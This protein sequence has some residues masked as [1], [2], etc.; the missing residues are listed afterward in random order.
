MVE[1]GK[2]AAK[3]EDANETG[4]RG[5]PSAWKW[6]VGAVAVAVV[7]WQVTQGVFVK[8]V[9]VPGGGEISFYPP[10]DAD[11]PNPNKATIRGA[12]NTVDQSG[13]AGN[14][15]TINGYRNVI[16]Q[17]GSNNRAT[18]GGPND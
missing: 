1:D 18:T 6:I 16:V 9:S 14:R 8:S 2:T 10:R 4:Q 17:H 3:P 7:V 15:A 13:E 5:I 12:D 11:R